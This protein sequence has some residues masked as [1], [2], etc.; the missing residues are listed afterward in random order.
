MRIHIVKPMTK[1]IREY[2]S[3]IMG[4]CHVNTIFHLTSA[5]T[6][7]GAPELSTVFCPPPAGPVVVVVPCAAA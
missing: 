5:Q 4:A 2:D 7:G 6:G 3:S 1:P